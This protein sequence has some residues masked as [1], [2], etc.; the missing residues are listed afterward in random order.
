MTGRNWEDPRSYSVKLFNASFGGREHPISRNP[1][2]SRS[3][4]DL[5]KSAI[6]E[7]TILMKDT[8][9]VDTMSNNGIASV[10]NL[11]LGRHTGQFHHDPMG[12]SYQVRKPDGMV[13]TNMNDVSFSW[14]G[15][16]MTFLG[17][18]DPVDNDVENTIIS[19]AYRA[20]DEPAVFASDE[21]LSSPVKPK[22]KSITFADQSKVSHAG[23][24]KPGTRECL[25]V[26]S[27]SAKVGEEVNFIP[28]AWE[29]E[30]IERVGGKQKFGRRKTRVRRRRRRRTRK[31]Y[32]T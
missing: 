3:I 14:F 8:G 15:T 11:K 9:M 27:R 12:T 22:D 23:V 32:P 31:K 26:I 18:N 30:I 29:A 16:L 7:Q 2:Q 13:M 5:Y 24:P 25:I 19:M 6:I 10:L 21:D 1:P 20:G 17:L 28:R 4:D